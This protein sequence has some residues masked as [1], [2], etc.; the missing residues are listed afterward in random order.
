MIKLVRL[1]FDVNVQLITDL[2]AAIH[3]HTKNMAL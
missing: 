2:D 3:V 1:F